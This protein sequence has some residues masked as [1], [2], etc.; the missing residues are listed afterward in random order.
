[1]YYNTAE[2]FVYAIHDENV[3]EVNASATLKQFISILMNTEQFTIVIC[4]PYNE[5]F[6]SEPLDKTLRDIRTEVDVFQFDIITPM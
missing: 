5:Q 1:M 4:H 6:T 2:D 3:Y